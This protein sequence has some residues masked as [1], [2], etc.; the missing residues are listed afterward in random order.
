M[1]RKQLLHNIAT[2]EEE[3]RYE[4]KANEQRAEREFEANA[5]DAERIDVWWLVG[6]VVVGLV[7]AWAYYG[8][9]VRDAI[10]GVGS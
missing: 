9:I 7:I 1:D 4:H 10:H 8:P 3:E 2:T 6:L 5:K